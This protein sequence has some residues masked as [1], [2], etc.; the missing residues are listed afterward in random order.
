MRE[1]TREKVGH[2]PALT[3]PHRRQEIEKHNT[4]YDIHS[5]MLQEIG[6]KSNSVRILT[7]FEPIHWWIPNA[8]TK[9]VVEPCLN[10]VLSCFHNEE[11]Y[12][13]N[14]IPQV[15]YGPS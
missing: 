11:Q 13:V 6:E 5:H 14:T 1:I 9:R 4:L 8:I 10:L 7:V 2:S 15:K 12:F 3:T